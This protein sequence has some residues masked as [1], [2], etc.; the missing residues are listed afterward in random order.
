MSFGLTITAA[1]GECRTVIRSYRA[2]EGENKWMRREGDE[3]RKPWEGCG[4]IGGFLWTKSKATIHEGG[5]T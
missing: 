4:R 1:A 2:W 3:R 5:T